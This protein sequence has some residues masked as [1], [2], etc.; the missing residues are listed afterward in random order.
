VLAAI[1][2]VDACTGCKFTTLY[3]FLTY[4]GLYKFGDGTDRAVRRFL[5]AM[6]Q[7]STKKPAIRTTSLDTLEALSP[8]L[9]N[10]NSL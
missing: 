6:Q 10:Q 2:Q 8:K 7:T 4:S 1:T 9:F 5:L 3:I